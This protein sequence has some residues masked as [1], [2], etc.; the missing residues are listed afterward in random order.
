MSKKIGKI[1][2]RNM[3]GTIPIYLRITVDGISKRIIN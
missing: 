2:S 1:Y 3:A